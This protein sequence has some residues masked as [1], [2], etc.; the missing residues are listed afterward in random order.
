MRHPGSGPQHTLSPQPSLTD[1]RRE[2]GGVGGVSRDC[3]LTIRGSILPS[4][5]LPP[6]L[7]SLYPIYPFSFPSQ[8]TFP[9]LL[10][11]FLHRLHPFASS[12][13]TPSIHPS[14]G[15]FPERPAWRPD[16]KENDTWGLQGSGR[17]A[18][19]LVKVPDLG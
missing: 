10:P 13:S 11:L 6:F 9:P 15:F 2:R 17:W 16:V 1:G 7:P 12:S 8:P 14:S 18:V 3:I 19:P 5:N 4:R